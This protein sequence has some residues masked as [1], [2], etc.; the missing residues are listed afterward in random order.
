MLLLLQVLLAALILLCR[1]FQGDVAVL[2]QILLDIQF[3]GRQVLQ[4]L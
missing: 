1:L 2:D 4:F 3:A